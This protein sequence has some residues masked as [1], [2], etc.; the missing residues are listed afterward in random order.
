MAQRRSKFDGL[1]A[2]VSRPGVPGPGVPGPG[3]PGPGVL[4]SKIFLVFTSKFYSHFK[5]SKDFL[6]K[7]PKARAHGLKPSL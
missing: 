3:V 7:T 2:R 4:N 1:S 5:P 6:I